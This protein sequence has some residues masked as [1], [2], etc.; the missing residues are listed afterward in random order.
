[1]FK[2]IVSYPGFWKSVASI[3]VAFAI[4]YTLF[5]WLLEGYSFAFINRI[6]IYILGVLGAGFVYA[7]LVTYGKFWKR[8]KDK[9]H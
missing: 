5:K 6:E 1:M 9:N 4:L 7:F 3:A 8:L 2:R